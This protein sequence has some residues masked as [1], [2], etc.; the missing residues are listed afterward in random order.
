MSCDLHTHS[1][2]SDATV[3]PS[4]IVSL[5]SDMGLYAAALC[6]HNTVSGVPEFLKSA[7]SKSLNAVAGCEFSSDY[8]G[9]EIHILA[10]F[11][12]ENRLS[13]VS[14]FTENYLIKKDNTNRDLV[15]ALNSCGFNID[16]DEIKSREKGSIN[17]AHIAYALKEK[18]YCKSINEVFDTIFKLPEIRAVKSFRPEGLDVISFINDICAVSVIA[19]PFLSFKKSDILYSFLKSAKKAGLDGI[20]TRYSLYSKENEMQADELSERFS[21]LKSGGSDFHADIKPDI[22]LGTG[23]GS[24]EVPDEYYEMLLERKRKKG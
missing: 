23:K 3:S 11:I 1:Y 2:F 7:K 16:Y 5:A 14:R 15:K 9:T 19:H 10:L 20:E 18:G 6:D 12:D 22:K 21:L 8:C 4:E 24:L 17:R 13:D